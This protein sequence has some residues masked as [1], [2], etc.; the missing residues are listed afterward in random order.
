MDSATAI[1]LASLTGSNAPVACQTDT[2]GFSPGN[3][4]SAAAITKA[5][6]MLPGT[7]A[8]GTVYMLLTEFTGT[9]EGHALAWQVN[10]NGAWTQLAPSVGATSWSAATA[11]AGYLALT[12]RVLSAT[13]AQFF[14]GGAI[15]ETG[16]SVLPGTSTIALTPLSQVLT[17]A[18]GDTLELGYLFGIT[19][20]GQ[21]VTTFGSTFLTL[22]AG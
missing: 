13:T 14:L 22:G 10:I 16:S 2:T 20:A 18:A 4:T 15:G 12:V 17:V 3:V 5:W 11:I 21:G 1:L 7:P 8:A 19:G 6:P 9:W